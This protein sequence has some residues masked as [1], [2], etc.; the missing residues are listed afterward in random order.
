MKK[1]TYKISLFLILA[2]AIS[3]CTEQYVFQNTDFE[4]ALVVE[5]TITNELK[6]QTI[7]LSQVYQLEE[8][9]PRFEKGASVFVL[10]D[11]GNEYQ[12]T[13]K[14]TVY[15]SITPFKAEPGR[16]YQLKIKTREGKNYTSDEQILTTETKIDNLTATVENVGGERGVQ[17]NVNSFDPNNTS[18]YYRY[19]YTETY[20]IIAPMWDS[21]EAIIVDIPA[22]PGNPIEGTPPSPASEVIVVRPRNKETKTCFSSK[23]SNE[24]ILNNT[25]SLSEDRV[26]FP[27]RFIS[28]QNYIIT[29]RYTIFVKQYVQ[30]LAAY[31]Y[32]KTLKELSS[33]GSV[34]SPKQPGFFYGNMRSVENPTEK[35]I[36]FFEVSAVSSERIFF[37]Y[38]DLFPNEPLP[39]YYETDCNIRDFVDCIGDPPC[40]GVQLR[41]VI[42]SR[43]LVHFSSN[44]SS[45]GL[46]KPACGDCTTFSSNIVPP[47]WID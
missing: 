3:S 45:Y 2:F 5:G 21:R 47:F 22:D 38:A 8:S 36:G 20:K 32:Y 24:I 35:V 7:R 12:F 14:D 1:I 9:G 42:R 44:L 23:K 33:S 39:P 10:D 30:S 16:K 19:E 18:K 29:N 26:H 25:N 4:S 6:N 28:N 41:T 13:E 34:L 15:E 37:N 40:A 46:V 17:I 31:T 43:E 11:K 27:V